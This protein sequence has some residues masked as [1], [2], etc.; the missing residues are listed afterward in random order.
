ML[1]GSVRVRKPGR[2]PP[3]NGKARGD[4]S[5]RSSGSR[6][7]SPGEGDEEAGSEKGGSQMDGA[8]AA[9]GEAREGASAP[10]DGRGTGGECA[11]GS[12]SNNLGHDVDNSSSG[13]LSLLEPHPLHSQRKGLD[14][15][16]SMNSSSSVTSSSSSSASS[17]VCHA[18]EAG[19]PS[20]VVA[21]NPG[22]LQ[23]REA[24]VLPAAAE[25]HGAAGV[26][27]CGS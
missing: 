15:S 22:R 10:A 18:T 3:S 16:S 17:S 12:S 4:S 8:T 2:R 13:H 23:L 20:E 26:L 11:S 7:S 1:V 21:V 24:V 6:R 5:S 27:P 14:S 9:V 25:L 19:W